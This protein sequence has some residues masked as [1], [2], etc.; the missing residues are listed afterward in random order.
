MPFQGIK[1]G[2]ATNNVIPAGNV[3]TC[4]KVKDAGIKVNVTV[5]AGLGGKELSKQHAVNTAKILN[6]AKP[7]QIAVLIDTRIRRRPE[8]QVYPEKPKGDHRGG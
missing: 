1:N 8:A 7:D 3:A 6:L 5:I 2:V 4:L